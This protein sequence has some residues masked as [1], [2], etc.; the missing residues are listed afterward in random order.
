MGIR[1]DIADAIGSLA[2]SLPEATATMRHGTECGDVIQTTGRDFADPVSDAGPAEVARFVGKT[3][4]FPS[5]AVGAAV[6]LGETLRVVTSLKG[7]P[8][9]A[10]FAVGLSAE[11]EKHPA[12]YKGTRREEGAV[13]HIAHTF[14]VLLLESGTADT[15][16]DALAPSYAA[17]YTVAIRRADWCEV[18]DPDP[19][20]TISVAPGGHP[21]TLKV[22]TVERHD[23]WFLLKCRARG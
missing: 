3:F 18:T 11:F 2:G 16:Q 19:A 15:Y 8:V 5:L 12:A 13:R 20:D 9:G 1:E 10:T 7:D 17:A 4:D 14:D 22:S 6:E 23:G 21:L